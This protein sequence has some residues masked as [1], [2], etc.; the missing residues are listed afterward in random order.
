MKTFKLLPLLFITSVLII[1]C[2]TTQPDITD[3][4]E[5][6][7]V[8]ISGAAAHWISGDRL[9][10]DSETS[11]SYYELRYSSDA[12]I[13][14]HQTEVTGGT[15]IELMPD[16]V[17]DTYQS[18]KFRHI[19]DRPV[20]DV[21]ANEET[22]KEALRGQLIAVAYNDDHQPVAA[23]KVQPH[24]VIDDFYTYDGDLGLTYVD[25]QI[26]LKIWAPTAQELAINIYMDDKSL[27]RTVEP[28]VERPETGVWTFFVDEEFDRHFYRLDMTLYHPENGEINEFEVTDPFSISLSTD[29]RYSQF[30]NIENDMDLKPAGWDD[31]R[32]ELPAATDISLYEAHMRDFSIGDF[33]VPEEHRGTYMAFT[34][35]GV[36]GRNLSDGM[37]HL[38]DLQTSGLTHLH[39]LPVNDIA[40]IIEDED[41]RVDL[42]DPFSKFCELT[43]HEK[44]QANCDRY[45]DTPI[46]EIFEE[47]AANDPLTKEIQA[48]M[49][50]PDHPGLSD[51]DG[52]NWGYDPFHFDAPEGSYSTDP[53]G[54]QR[55][56]ELREMVKALHE[57]GLNIVVDV[58]YN[59]TH[60]VGFHD[61]SVLDQVVPW[62]YHRLDTNTG[63]VE[64]S[65]CCPNTAAEFNMKEKLII[66]SV[67]FWAKQYK[68][69]SFRFDLM[70]HHPRYV[71]EN[72]QEELSKL[73][74]E[75]DGVDGENIFIYGEGWNFGEVADDRIFIQATQFNMGGTGIGNFND[76]IRDGIKGPFYAGNGRSAQGFANG[77]YLFPNEVN[78]ASD[79]ARHELLGMADRVRVGMTGN[80]STY[81]YENR[82][83][84][85]V[86]GENEGIGYAIDPQESINYIDKH[87]NETLWDDAQ[88][89]LPFDFSMDDRV[90]VHML[91]N[92]IINFGQGIPF[93][94]LGT[95]MLRSKSMD[96][97]SYQSGDWFNTVDFT[98]ESHNWELGMP[99]AWDNRE[100]WD[101]IEEIKRE[102]NVDVQQEHMELAHALF[103][104]QLQI[105]Y[106]SPL[107][108]LATGDDVHERVAFHNTGADQIPG[109]IAKTISD[110]ACVDEQID[111]YLDGI[112]IIVNSDNQ[113]Q[114]FDLGISGL[115]L[116]NVHAESIDQ[117][118]RQSVEQNGVV[119]IPA[120][121]T[122]VFVNPTEDEKPGDFPCNPYNSEY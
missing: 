86:L 27:V 110:G 111:P 15:A 4:S 21:D 23:T 57:V 17:L 92:A 116:H 119:T 77:L 87:D 44:V 40:T 6:M 59:H 68:I 104:E 3:D 73:T 94:Q 66:D 100:R 60:A 56:L 42:D 14:V 30:V 22:V 81:R 32:K 67:V 50:S 70:G 109:I 63:E 120:L 12:D 99:P 117:T 43:D 113:E 64:T 33:T 118:V 96:R 29:S 84:E 45:G 37:S 83:G 39:L 2:G 97:N 112:V 82:F 80:L 115:N 28:E 78:E 18:D 1:S 19:A 72:L 75:E 48:Y 46:R 122:A 107:F 26:E 105:R 49:H 90:R 62:Y 53:D 16:A 5:D 11:A 88:A 38:I 121:T 114:T 55:I 54:A 7:D 91:K 31:I 65:T 85:T 93:Y 10:W 20:F 34:H 58:V 9:I 8:S 24:G 36:H 69:D 79:E 25:G 74:L 47:L 41:Q 103:K 51:I 76:R 106:S 35:N 95:D 61:K 102:A 52:F 13:D 71:M 98:M 108:R 89:K 101:D